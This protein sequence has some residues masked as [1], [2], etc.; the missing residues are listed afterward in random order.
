MQLQ[1]FRRPRRWLPLLLVAVLFVP[2]LAAPAHAQGLAD[3]GYSLTLTISNG[4]SFNYGGTMPIFMAYLT[5][6]P[7]GAGPDPSQLIL[8]VDGQSNASEMSGTNS[9][10]AIGIRTTIGQLQPGN[11]TAIQIVRI[12]GSQTAIQS[13]PLT[14]TIGK[15][16][17]SLSCNI[18]NLAYVY[19]QGEMLHVAM[20]F[21]TGSV[22]VDWQDGTYTLTFV[23]TTTVTDANLAPDSN[24]V[25]SAPAPS[26]IG[27]YQLRCDFS[28]TALVAPPS[29]FTLGVTVSL[30]NAVGSVQVYTNPTT[31]A[32]RQPADLYVVFNA[33]NSLPAPTGR[34]YININGTS[35]TPVTLGSDGTVLAHIPQVPDLIGAST[36]SIFYAGD[37]N[38][39]SGKF[40]FPLT[41]APIPGSPGGS[42]G[43][44]G[45][46]G[47]SSGGGTTS[48]PQG[49]A[50]PTKT[51]TTSA[52]PARTALS[53]PVS[54]TPATAAS[55]MAAGRPGN[56]SGDSVPLW[57]IALLILVAVCAGGGIVVWRRRAK[58]AVPVT[59]AAPGAAA[60]EFRWPSSSWPPTDE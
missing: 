32:S 49:A 56:T 5:V 4:S 23:G 17:A 7:G 34:F 11:H 42:G 8:Q 3:N 2:W 14:F 53:S 21:S 43:S 1:S 35:S 31:L 27:D 29:G 45:S 30:E 22:P 6:P 41:N 24:D 40:T 38:Y 19:S 50:T 26:Q 36:F 10:G 58:A 13:S 33:A 20:Q 15:A 37:P 12:L 54:A 25:V 47:G 18:Q 59:S 44:G 16:S 46:S 60:T 52:T 55:V 48:A 28:G 39:N 57:L 51:A 9:D